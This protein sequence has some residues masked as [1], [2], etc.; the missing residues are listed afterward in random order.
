MST[1]DFSDFLEVL[2]GE[3]FEEI[4]VTIE[5]FVTDKEFLGL[6]PLSDYQYQMINA[7]TQI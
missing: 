5:T 2:D 6:P 1:I 3:V 7:S 4:P